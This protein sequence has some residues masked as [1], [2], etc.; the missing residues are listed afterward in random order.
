MYL[1]RQD[2]YIFIGILWYIVWISW[3]RVQDWICVFLMMLLL[4]KL[5]LWL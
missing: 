5:P 3:K 2:S 4:L 1:K